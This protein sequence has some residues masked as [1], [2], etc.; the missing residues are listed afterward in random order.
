[1]TLDN[2]TDDH[3]NHVQVKEEQEE[4]A[5]V[6]DI[7]KEEVVRQWEEKQAQS[8]RVQVPTSWDN[9]TQPTDSDVH[10]SQG[11]NRR[12]RPTNVYRWTRNSKFDP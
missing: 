1:M 5:E 11:H 10:S 9:Q 12:I 4:E 8:E 2:I 7:T 6:A 3:E